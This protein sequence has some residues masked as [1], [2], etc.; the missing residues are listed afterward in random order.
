MM[1]IWKSVSGYVGFY[2]VSNKGRVRSVRRVVSSL[3]F[4]AISIRGRILIPS[5]TK[6]GYRFVSLCVFGKRKTHLISRLVALAFIPNPN[7]LSDVN[8]VD[9]DKSNNRAGN[10]EWST[11]GDNMRHA[12]KNGAYKIVNG[13][14]K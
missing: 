12:W 14:P 5:V 9:L 1:E 13:R 4:K 11:H 10:L 3:R 7:G 6:K 8:H 2:E